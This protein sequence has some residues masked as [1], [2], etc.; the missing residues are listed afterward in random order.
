MAK[1]RSKLQIDAD[2]IIKD[3]LNDM[4][5]L[6]YQEARATSRVDTGRLRDSVNYRVKPDTTL[7]IA[8]VFYGK[9]NYPKGQNSG[10]K[11]ALLIAAQKYVDQTTNLIVTE[12]NDTLIQP[13]KGP[14]KV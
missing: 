6:I 1:R 5:E 11:N 3:K 9:Y 2:Q 13:F 8:Q 14:R 4:G 7:T 12:I 10:E